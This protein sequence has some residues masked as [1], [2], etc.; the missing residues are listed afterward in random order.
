M[1]R[2]YGDK[3]DEIINNNLENREIRKIKWEKNVSRS[4]QAPKASGAGK[5]LSRLAVSVSAREASAPQGT[6]LTPQSHDSW[7]CFC[8][9]RHRQSRNAFV[10]FL[11]L[12]WIFYMFLK[13][14]PNVL[15]LTPTPCKRVFSVTRKHSQLS[16][17]VRFWCPQCS[18]LQPR[19]GALTFF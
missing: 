9:S 11:I 14:P 10:S 16:D 13:K 17:V 12:I 5:R 7:E 6:C 19:W 18:L 4:V 8:R 1:W 15:Q 2:I 3:H